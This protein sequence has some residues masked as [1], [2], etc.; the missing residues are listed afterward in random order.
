MVIEPGNNVNSA[1]N[2]A[3]K[4]RQGQARSADSAASKSTNSASDNSADSVSLSNTGQSLNR[5]EAAVAN[6]PETNLEKVAELKSSVEN[7]SYQINAYNLAGKM[8]AQDDF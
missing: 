4:A 3:G 5:L 6:S 2:A 7:G 1:S 8:L